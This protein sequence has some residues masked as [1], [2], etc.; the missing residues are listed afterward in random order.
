MN[1]IIAVPAALCD[2]AHMSEELPNTERPL[3]DILNK[4]DEI[5]MGED[6]DLHTVIA[7]FGDRAFG[8]VLT[9]CGLL[10]L[11]PIGA[12][13]GVPIALGIVIISF[14]GQLVFGRDTPWMPEFLRKV[15]IKHSAIEKSRKRVGPILNKID[16]VIR[17]R[18]KWAAT[19]TARTLAALI[20]VVFAITL[21]PLGS[22]PFGVVI[23]G[24]II[25]LIGLGITARDG[26]ILILGFALSI[27]A[28]AIIVKL[29]LMAY[30]AV[31]G[32]GSI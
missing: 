4:V 27:G 19:D 20:S 6:T 25:T 14:A 31:S 22:V 29:V 28:G 8:P 30:L 2:M 11:T 24:L 17:P 1:K 3:G 9:L 10:H 18:Y 26:L 13:P 12:L 23:P 32:G 16:A 5:A 21:L 15:K 7:A